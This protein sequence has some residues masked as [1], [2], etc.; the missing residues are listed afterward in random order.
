MS[1]DITFCSNIKCKNKKCTSNQN[2]Y[3]LSFANIGNHPIS[4]ADYSQDCSD[5]IER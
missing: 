2:N 1:L 5:K 3:D 4:I